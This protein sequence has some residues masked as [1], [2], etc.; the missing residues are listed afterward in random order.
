[1][2][3]RPD[4]Q[5]SAADVRDR[6]RRTAGA[7]A[8]IARHTLAR[9]LRSIDPTHARVLL[10]EGSPRVLSSYPADLSASA[11]RA[12][13]RLGVEVRTVARV[14]AMTAEALRPVRFF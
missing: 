4:G 8:E 5:A 13:C 12:L 11:E 10:C 6:R 14:T 7:I 2:G 3:A 9:D 1:M